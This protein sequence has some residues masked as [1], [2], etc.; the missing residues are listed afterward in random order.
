MCVYPAIDWH[1]SGG[2]LPVIG[3]CPPLVT[4]NCISSSNLYRSSA[5]EGKP[6]NSRTSC[7]T[8]GL[9]PVS[10]KEQDPHDHGYQRRSIMHA[11]PGSVTV[12]KLMVLRTG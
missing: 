5:L 2:S 9:V 10:V 6:F 3:S 1:V 11:C 4:T 7:V 8:Q 12:V